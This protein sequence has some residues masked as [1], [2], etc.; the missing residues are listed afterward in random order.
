MTEDDSVT[1]ADYIQVP[2]G[3]L[4]WT[5]GRKQEKLWWVVGAGASAVVEW[6]IQVDLSDCDKNHPCTCLGFEAYELGSD[7]NLLE[8]AR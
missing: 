4:T 8:V 6:K 1:I 2:D 7:G 3:E 5:P